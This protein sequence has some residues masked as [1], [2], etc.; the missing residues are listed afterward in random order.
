MMDPMEKESKLAVLKDLMKQM[1][2]IVVEMEGGKP[3]GSAAEEASESP[4][5]EAMEGDEGKEAPSEDAMKSS[6]PDEGA[7][8]DGLKD[9][10]E[11]KG[12]DRAKKVGSMMGMSGMPSAKKPPMGRFGK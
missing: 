3:E 5:E 4:D 9:F 11:E 10:M 8:E 6:M 2:D 1:S 12:P 7:P